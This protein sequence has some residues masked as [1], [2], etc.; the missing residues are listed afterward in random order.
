LHSIDWS[1][2]FIDRYW[3]IWQQIHPSQALSYTGQSSYPP[4]SYSNSNNKISV[5]LE[6]MMPGLNAPVRTAMRSDGGGG[7]CI[8]YS[9]Y[10][11][12]RRDP[13]TGKN[14]PNY[15]SIGGVLKRMN[16]NTRRRRKVGGW[17]GDGYGNVMEPRKPV[18]KL[19]KEWVMS[20]TPTSHGM[21]QK[22]HPL[23]KG[24]E[25][26]SESSPSTETTEESAVG[27]NTKDPESVNRVRQGEAMLNS[28]G[29]QFDQKMKAYMIK[30]PHAV[31][32]DAYEH[33]MENWEWK[34]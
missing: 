4:L 25:T 26:L 15:Q 21:N 16:A 8:R 20:H 14:N 1:S 12:Y 32:E 24:N 5:H 18:P 6:D 23:D 3:H 19:P 31:Y 33:V 30:H 22:I 9:L 28:I 27:A 13:F 34:S 11:R 17:E 29:A 10:S 7:Y 2:I